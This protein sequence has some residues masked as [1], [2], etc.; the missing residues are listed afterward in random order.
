MTEVSIN[1]DV[2]PSGTG[3]AECL[4]AQGWWVHLRRCAACGHVGCCDSSPGQHATGHYRETGHPVMQSFEPGEDWF[5]D[6]PTESPTDGPALAEPSAHPE[7]QPAPGPAG[8]V[9]ADWQDKIH[10]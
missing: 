8:A 1:P 4:T 3:C 2:P 10:R 6:F 5:W 7:D 9:P